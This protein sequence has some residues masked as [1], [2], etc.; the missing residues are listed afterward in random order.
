MVLA[1]LFILQLPRRIICL[2]VGPRIGAHTGTETLVIIHL[3][4]VP[5]GFSR[6]PLDI[7]PPKAHQCCLGRLLG[8]VFSGEHLIPTVGG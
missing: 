3:Q 1:A 6:A 8:S 7:I 4:S 2:P 5:P